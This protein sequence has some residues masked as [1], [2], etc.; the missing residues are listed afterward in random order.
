M[1]AYAE[2]IG[3]C[4]ECQKYRLGPLRTDGRLASYQIFEELAID[5]EVFKRPQG[6]VHAPVPNNIVVDLHEI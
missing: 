1:E 5:F 2:F 4:P 6:C 3:D